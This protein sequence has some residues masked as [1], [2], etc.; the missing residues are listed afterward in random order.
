[1]TVFCSLAAFCVFMMACCACLVSLLLLATYL[2]EIL[3][4]F[5]ETRMTYT[6]LL[7]HIAILFSIP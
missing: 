6:W 2:I 5:A 1:L 3:L 7:F 4:L